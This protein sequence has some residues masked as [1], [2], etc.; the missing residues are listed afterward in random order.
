LAGLRDEARVGGGQLPVE[1]PHESPSQPIRQRGS[2]L[3]DQQIASTAPIDGY[4]SLCGIGTTLQISVYA[5]SKQE[6]LI[7]DLYDARLVSMHCNKMLFAGIERT[8]D[9]LAAQYLQ[10]WSAVIVEL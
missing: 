3:S 10:E 7:P 5:N 8:A 4:L 2:H 9:P 6:S 1:W